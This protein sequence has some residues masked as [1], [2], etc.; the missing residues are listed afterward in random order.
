MR[1]EKEDTITEKLNE[2]QTS[3]DP[4]ILRRKMQSKVIKKILAEIDLPVEPD[5]D[6]IPIPDPESSNRVLPAKKN[7]KEKTN[8]PKKMSD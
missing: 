6:I 3:I 4:F 1:K 2:E 7:N 8:V 5:K